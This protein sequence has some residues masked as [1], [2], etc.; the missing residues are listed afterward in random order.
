M[1]LQ[2]GAVQHEQRERKHADGEQHA[3]NKNT[4]TGSTR[5]SSSSPSSSSRSSSSSSSSSSGGAV[6]SSNSSDPIFDRNDGPS[7]TPLISL[8]GIGEPTDPRLRQR[9]RNT[10]RGSENQPPPPEAQPSATGAVSSGSE[11]TPLTA[12]QS[13]PPPP[14]VPHA[15][16]LDPTVVFVSHTPLPQPPFMTAPG[17]DP[18]PDPAMDPSPLGK[19]SPSPSSSD[20]EDDR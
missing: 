8:G 11:V 16:A 10:R 3:S 9:F 14:S 15:P 7:G 19:I 13:A 17:T 20:K 1:I 4:P 18:N 6:S 2:P 12:V 5:S